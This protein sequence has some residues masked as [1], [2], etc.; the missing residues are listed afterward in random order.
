MSGQYNHIKEEWKKQNPDKES[1]ENISEKSKI[2]FAFSLGCKESFKDMA[3]HERSTENPPYFQEYDVSCTK[4]GLQLD[5]VCGYV[6]TDLECP[7][8]LRPARS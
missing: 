2:N 6:C 3:E 1:W 7:S 8:G 5:K 4:C